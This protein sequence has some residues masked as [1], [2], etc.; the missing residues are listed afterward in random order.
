MMS[1]K[2]LYCI[3]TSITVGVLKFLGKQDF[4]FAQISPLTKFVQILLYRSVDNIGRYLTSNIGIGF[5][6]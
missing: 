6:N 5:N 1:F 3:S 4:D 2:S